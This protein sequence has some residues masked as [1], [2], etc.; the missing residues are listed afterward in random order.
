MRSFRSSRTAL[1]VAAFAAL[2]IA[3]CG[4]G[5]SLLDGNSAAAPAQTIVSVG[6]RP[7]LKMVSLRPISG[8][9]DDVSAELGRQLNEAANEQGIALIVDQNIKSEYALRGYVTA[10]KNGPNVNV[11]YLWDVVDARGQR[12]SR[13]EGEEALSGSADAKAPW[14]AVT[15][16]ASRAIAQRSMGE[17]VKWLKANDRSLSATALPQSAPVGGLGLSAAQ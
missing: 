12:V 5:T 7:I 6:A 1:A 9:P 13:I 14:T 8:P 4:S 15:P 3:A 11:S 10:L 2:P 16:A 17:L